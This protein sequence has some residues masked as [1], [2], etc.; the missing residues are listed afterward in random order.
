MAH[1]SEDRVLES[2]VGVATTAFTLAGAVAGFRTFASQMA[3]ND[4]CWYAAWAVDANGTPTGQFENGLGTLTAA[5]TLTRTTVLESSNANAAV[6]FTGTLYVAI[7]LL[8]SRTAYF[9]DT[10]SMFM[11]TATAE[12]PTPVGGIEVYARE[13]VPGN[14]VLKIKRPSGVDSPI[15]DGIAFNRF[16]KYQGGGAALVAIG[17]GALTTTGSTLTAIAPTSGTNIRNALPRT[18]FSTAATANS[19]ANAVA[20][21]NVLAT[22][23][24]R[25]SIAG[26][27][28][29]RVVM[30]FNISALQSPNRFF[31]GLRDVATAATNVDPFTSTTPGSV[32]LA[33][34]TATSANWRIVHNVSGTAPTNIDLGANFPVNTTDLLE[35]ILFC[36]P[37]TGV[38]VGDTIRYRCRRFTTS[39]DPT[40]EAT[41]NLTT[42]IP[43]LST[44]LHPGLW[45]VTGTAAVSS[46]QINSLSIE[47]DF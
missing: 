38:G 32:G 30:R 8:A 19:V 36:P 34:N 45:M 5:T 29:F 16:V 13:I 28:G 4:T 17:G 1:I 2:A 44:L 41:G 22:H 33:F 3:T 43:G 31:A 46:F 39:G 9:D 18:Q 12:P 7:S 35:L 21:G 10:H 26:E 27:G 6:T 20:G 23:V 37:A 42:N 14:T 25:G 11:P 24:L 40:A 47:S 15:Q